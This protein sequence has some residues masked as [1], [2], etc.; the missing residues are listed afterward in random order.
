[1]T[2][3]ENFVEC[4]KNPDFF[5]GSP[6]VESWTSPERPTCFL[7]DRGGEASTDLPGTI[8]NH[9]LVDVWWN[10][11]FL[12][13][14][15]ESSK[16]KQPFL[17]GCFRFQVHDNFWKWCFFFGGFETHGRRERWRGGGGVTSHS[18]VIY[19]SMQV[20]LTFCT[21]RLKNWMMD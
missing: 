21:N 20:H 13:N 2:L 14:D 12:C 18:L 11:H 4:Q 17:N 7:G 15:L 6:Q 16:L 10:N 19:V 1:M 5:G 3:A 8:N 9:L